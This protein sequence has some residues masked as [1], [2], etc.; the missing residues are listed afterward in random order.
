MKG[1]LKFVF[2]LGMLFL[3]ALLFLSIV[4][5]SLFTKVDGQKRIWFELTFLLLA[6][7]LANTLVANYFRQ[8]QAMALL[9]V[10]ILISPGVVGLAWPVIRGVLPFAPAGEPNFV[11]MNETIGLLAK[12]GSIVLLFKIGMQS[13]ARHIFTAKNLVIA[14]VGVIIPFAGG[15]W[16]GLEYLKTG[17]AEAIFLGAALTATSVGITLAIIEEM[18]ALK[19]DF[20]RM[21]LGAAVIDDVLAL[22]VLSFAAMLAVPGGAGGS[23][24]VVNFAWMAGS[25]LVFIIGGIRIGTLFVERHF[26]PKEGEKLESTAFL[27]MMTFL[28]LYAYIAEFIGLSAIVGAFVAGITLNY[29]K[30]AKALLESVFP[31]ESLFV[32]IFFISLGMMVD[33]A[34]LVQFAVPI[35]A[36]TAVA[37]ATKVAGCG[38]AA[39][40]SGAGWRNSLIVGIGMNPRGEIALIIAAFGLGAG[41]LGK[42]EY[43]IIVAMAFLTT[44]ITPPLLN[45]MMGRVKIAKGEN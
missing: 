19:T 28:F 6:A 37:T 44:V 34:S 4:R 42:P 12:L 23:G 5:A 8:P 13:Q 33:V 22:L 15:Y 38:A 10:G 9:I 16:F 31:L 43:S 25:A 35:L 39:R 24:L 14:T 2:T 1:T 36:L 26:T 32:P 3:F 40:A 18:K 11:T 29:S 41:I 20:A 17:I 7:I 27:R 21:I 30:N 45:A